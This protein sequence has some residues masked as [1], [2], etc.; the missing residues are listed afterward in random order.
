MS[1]D[2]KTNNASSSSTNK[3]YNR[4]NIVLYP[5]QKEDLDAF[6]KESNTNL[7]GVVR[8]FINIGLRLWKWQKDGGEI[9]LR[10]KNGKEKSI[11]IWW[12]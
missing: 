1:D 11:E 9:I 6:Q 8:H 5:T 10:D 4:L 12:I 3:T 2:Q 7:Q